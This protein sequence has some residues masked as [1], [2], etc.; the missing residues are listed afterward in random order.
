MYPQSDFIDQYV[1]LRACQNEIPHEFDFD[2]FNFFQVQ[3]QGQRVPPVI[4]AQTG[5]FFC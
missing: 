2:N 3:F 1:K 5:S 4:I